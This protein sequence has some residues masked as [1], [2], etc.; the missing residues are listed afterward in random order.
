MGVGT[1]ERR[2][3]V[4]ATGENSPTTRVGICGN[5]SAGF[6]FQGGYFV[7]ARYNVFDRIDSLNF[8]GFEL[9]VGVRLFDLR[10]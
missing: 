3:E 2:E 1:A 8:D 7:E 10:P 4:T 5:L 9:S 6:L